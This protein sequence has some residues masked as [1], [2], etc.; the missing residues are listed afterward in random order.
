LDGAIDLV[1]RFLLEREMEFRTLI[2]EAKIVVDSAYVALDRLNDAGEINAIR[3]MLKE[4][5]ELLAQA[6]AM[7]HS[8]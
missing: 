2:D 6:Q 5:D 3:E 1:S 7:K 8:G 4:A